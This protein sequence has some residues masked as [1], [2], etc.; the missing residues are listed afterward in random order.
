MSRRMPSINRRKLIAGATIAAGAALLSQPAQAE[1][2]PHMRAALESLRNA[3]SRLQQATPD[4]GGHRNRA[5]NLVEQAINE[6]QA[7]I[8]Y[9]NRR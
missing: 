1:N 8:A 2:Q 4:K 6:T 5:I 7:G 9:D 3:R